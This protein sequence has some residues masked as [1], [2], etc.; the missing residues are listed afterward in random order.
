MHR[1]CWDGGKRRGLWVVR[2]PDGG[3]QEG[4]CVAGEKRG[5]WVPRYADGTVEEGAVV[6]RKACEAEAQRARSHAPGT[7]FRDCPECPEVVAVVAGVMMGPIP[8]K[9]LRS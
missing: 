4:P 2:L 6:E 5:H 1:E 9:S 7:K 3:G 8:V